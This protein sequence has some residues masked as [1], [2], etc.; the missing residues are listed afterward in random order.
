VSPPP[1]GPSAFPDPFV[2]A[3]GGEYYAYATNGGG[4]NVRVITSSDLVNWQPLPEGLPHL[5]AW[6]QPNFTWSPSVLA[7]Q[8]RYVLYYA[9]RSA[10]G[11]LEAISVATSEHPGGPFTDTSAGPLI[12]Q[13]AQGGSIDPSPFVDAD[14]TA[15]LLWKED[16]N[17][18][19]QPSS[20]WIQQL[21]ADGLSLVGQPT[22]LL[23]YDAAWENPLI[24]APSVVLEGG[25]YFLFYSANWWNTSLYA[26]GYATASHVLGPYEKATK[27]GPWFRAD[28]EVAGPGG[29]EWFLDGQGQRHMAYHGWTPGQVNVPGGR[30]RSLRIVP[31]SFASGRPVALD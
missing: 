17:A 11:A 1:V 21:A 30:G 27:V 9:V 14:G 13:Q 6:S 24:E 25:T 7:R 20:L 26:I 2:L 10:L 22:A 18:I 4:S 15:Y 3:V 19:H 16:A 29:Q 28:A 8:G 12:Y 5:P 31:V 23:R